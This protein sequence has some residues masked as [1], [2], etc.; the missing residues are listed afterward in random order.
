[1]ASR[2]RNSEVRIIKGGT[3]FVKLP[4]MP[5]NVIQFLEFG[6]LALKQQHL[7][8][9]GDD[10]DASIHVKIVHDN[11]YTAPTT[12]GT[13]ENLEIISQVTQ[14]PIEKVTGCLRASLRVLSLTLSSGSV[15]MRFSSDARYGCQTFG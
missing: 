1:M 8:F 12:R 13:L 9:R 4:H 7:I 11:I 2:D 5:K 15:R 6:N 10:F 3:F 14:Q